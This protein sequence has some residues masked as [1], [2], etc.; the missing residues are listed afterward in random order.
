MGISAVARVYALLLGGI[1]AA[2]LIG[3]GGSDQPAYNEA[4]YEDP[5]YAPNEDL[6]GDVPSVSLGGYTFSTTSDQLHHAYLGADPGTEG[7][8][9]EGFG[10]QV[11]ALA[12]LDYSYGG[13]V[14]GVKTL[15][16]R[17]TARLRTPDVLVDSLSWVA[18]DTAGN[19]HYLK[20]K[21]VVNGQTMTMGVARGDPVCFLLPAAVTVGK[22]WYVY[23]RGV[24][25]EMHKVLSLSASSQGTSGLAQVMFVH[26]DNFDGTFATSW[27]GPDD[28][29]DLFLS[30]SSYLHSRKLSQN[31]TGGLVK[32]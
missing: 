18:E 2:G 24:K 29:D 9:G 1:V 17:Q 6:D 27:S 5:S 12:V 8:V 11:G 14:S 26:D 31:P 10:N 30:P 32:R 25:E 16:I 13:L 20:Y 21:N 3:C 22:T 15:R 23:Y 7:W 19:V 4:L 28:R